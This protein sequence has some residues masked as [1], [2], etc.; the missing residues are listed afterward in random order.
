MAYPRTI[1]KR[2]GGPTRGGHLVAREQPG[3]EMQP[4]VHLW[5]LLPRHV[6]SSAKAGKCYLCARNE[7]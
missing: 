1:G 2:V 7:P 3:H 6:A 4:L 5:T